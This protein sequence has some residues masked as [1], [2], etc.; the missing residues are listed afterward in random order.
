[1][2]TIVRFAPSPTGRLHVGNARMA[3]VNYLFARQRNGLFVL[4]LDDTDTERSTVAFA[5]DIQAD[6]RWLGLLWD[7]CFKQSDRLTRYADVAASLRNSERLYP[8]YET[9]EE[10]ALKRKSQLSRGHPPIYDRAA[11]ALS[12]S[13][14][15]ALEASGRKPHWRFRLKPDAIEWTDLVRGAVRYLGAELSDP[16]LIRE[17]GRPLYTLSSVIDDADTCV[18]HVLRGEDHV[19]NTAVQIQLFE[20]L[21]APVPVFGH[22]SLLTDADGEGLSKRHGSLSLAD[23]RDHSEIEPMALNSYLAR[24]GTS[25]AIDVHT[26]LSELMDDFDIGKFSRATPRFDPQELQRLNARLLHHLPFDTVIDRLE[27]LGCTGVDFDAWRAI[28]PNLERL[29]DFK[30]WWQIVRTPIKPLIE[31]REMSNLAAELLPPE[32]WD[33]NTWSV[34]T[35]AIKAHTGL[36]GKSLYR[37]LRL[38]LTGRDQGPEL[39]TLLP[40]MTRDRVIARLKGFEA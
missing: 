13:D 29:S 24:L 25:E 38:A 7:Q 1:M 39:K 28:Q 14:R 26:S 11:L 18:S 40:L 36:K 2:T 20:A 37:P 22:L 10:L 19:T 5:E 33:L 6:L 34:W 3:L 21:D 27:H 8:C 30:A 17:D 4:R 12:D 35:Q 16:V 31:D 23:L 9:P 15:S 32:P